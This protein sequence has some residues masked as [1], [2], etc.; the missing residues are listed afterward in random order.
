MMRA[1]VVLPTP[2]GPQKIMEE[3]RSLSMSRRR[4]LPSPEQMLLPD[5]FRKRLGAQPRGK[6]LVGR[7]AEKGLLFHGGSS[8]YA[9]L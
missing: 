7:A 2:G 9:L 8:C 5:E 4:A 6:R 1:R 3:M